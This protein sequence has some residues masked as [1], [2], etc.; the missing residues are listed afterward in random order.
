MMSNKIDDIL[1][2]EKE[3]L[4]NQEML[5]LVHQ[6]PLGRPG[7]RYSDQNGIQIWGRPLSNGAW[8]AGLLNTNSTPQ[9]ITLVFAELGPSLIGKMVSVRDL[10]THVNLG[11]FHPSITIRQVAPHDTALLLLKPTE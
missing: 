2:W 1:P 4:T 3:I 5:K 7:I 6:D 9:D 8:A 11:T 10:W